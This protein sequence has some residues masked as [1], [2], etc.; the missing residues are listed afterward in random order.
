MLLQL[1]LHQIEIININGFPVPVKSNDDTQ[2]Y[3]SLC[4]SY[5]HY[6]KDKDL[7]IHRVQVTGKG[8]KGKVSRVEHQL[9]THKD[10]D[11]VPSYKNPQHSYKKENSA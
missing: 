6:K 1:P 10:N 8:N 4:G 11:G 3:S 2:S 7:T 5:R 9:N